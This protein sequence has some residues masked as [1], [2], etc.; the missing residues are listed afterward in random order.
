MV[1]QDSFEGLGTDNFGFWILEDCFIPHFK[2]GRPLV[3]FSET[4]LLTRVELSLNL[5]LLNNARNFFLSIID[6]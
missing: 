2:I 1:C 3:D 4:V 6:I 5:R